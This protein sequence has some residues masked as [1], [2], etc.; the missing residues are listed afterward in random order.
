MDKEERRDATLKL[1]LRPDLDIN[2]ETTG[3]ENWI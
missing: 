2:N 3:Y 1:L